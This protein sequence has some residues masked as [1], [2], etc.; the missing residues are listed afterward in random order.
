MISFSK[1]IIWLSRVLQESG[2]QVDKKVPFRSDNQAVITWTNGE[3]C[4]SKAAKRIGVRVHYIR[5][6][7]KSSQISVS[8]AASKDNDADI[9]TKPLGPASIDGVTKRLC[10]LGA[11][12]EECRCVVGNPSSNDKGAI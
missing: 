11:S 8:Y 7:I 5:E 10:L 4:P 6:H 9:L 2:L 3:R 12:E 1:E